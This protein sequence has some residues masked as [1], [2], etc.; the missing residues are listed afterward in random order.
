MK[1]G[2]PC[3]HCL[4]SK[5]GH[6][7]FLPER[8]STS[9]IESYTALGVATSN[10]AF[11]IKDTENEK[12]VAKLSRERLSL[13]TKVGTIEAYICAHCGFIEHYLQEPKW[14]TLTKVEGFSW[15]NKREKKSLSFF[16]LLFGR[17]TAK[18]EM[19]P[20]A[21][22]RRC[23]SERVG[24]LD[25]LPDTFG[26]EIQNRARCVGITSEGNQPVGRFQA[27]ICADCGFLE[28]FAFPIGEIDL[29]SID[30]LS[31]PEREDGGPYR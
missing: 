6:L 9:D 17:K 31:W 14:L 13:R 24:H 1:Q 4:S 18:E 25:H 12:S 23:N 19:K 30:G 28:F 20:K 22:C 8:A 26:K 11:V 10:A 2:T 3:P 27:T 5:I 15:I 16:D 7:D 29:E 21:V